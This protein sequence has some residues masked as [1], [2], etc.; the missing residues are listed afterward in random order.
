[1]NFMKNSAPTGQHGAAVFGTLSSAL[2]VFE[3]VRPRLNPPYD[4]SDVHGIAE[5][6]IFV[7]VLAT[8]ALVLGFIGLRSESRAC[9]YLALFSIVLTIAVVLVGIV[10]RLTNGG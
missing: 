4:P 7:V 1:M 6:M 5:E 2:F 8:I 10:A 9:R 3:L